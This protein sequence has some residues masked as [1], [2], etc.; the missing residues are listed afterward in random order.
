MTMKSEERVL[1]TFTVASEPGNERQALA[2]VADAVVDSGLS[3]DQ[4]NRL[5]TAVAEATMNAIEH[6]NHNQADLDV[7][8]SVVDTGERVTVS[9]TDLGGENAP[10]PDSPVELPDID[11]KLAGLQSPR[12]WGLFLI[13]NMV[14]AMEVSIDGAEHT[15]R[16]TMRTASSEQPVVEPRNP[17]GDHRAKQV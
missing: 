14:D 5:K 12:G 6:G 4:L 17:E 13:Q 16:L 1:L 3:D 15:V 10:A 8:I 2:R 11:M 7:T 9:I